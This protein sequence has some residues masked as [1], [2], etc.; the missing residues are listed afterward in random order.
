M[1]IIS[2]KVIVGC[3]G[4]N[5]VTLKIESDEGLIGIG[6]ATLNA[7]GLIDAVAAHC[8]SLRRHGVLAT[9]AAVA[10]SVGPTA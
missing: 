4:R 1:K 10:Q 5:F 7:A 8:L 3:P 6:D 2:A 9:L